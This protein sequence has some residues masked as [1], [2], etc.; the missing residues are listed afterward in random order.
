MIQTD[1]AVWQQLSDAGL[2]K[3]A[4]RPDIAV[5]A[6]WYV[7]ALLA[8]SGWLSA[9]FGFAFIGLT[10]GLLLESPVFS[11]IV[12]LALVVT[13][14]FI[15]RID[16]NEFVDNLGL[17]VSLVGQ[18][19][20]VWGLVT[21]D[22]A[23]N[24]NFVI[25]AISALYAVLILATGSYLHRVVFSIFLVCTVFTWIVTNRLPAMNIMLFLLPIA[26]LWLN[27]FR[28]PARASLVR[29]IAYGL[30]IGLITTIAVAGWSQGFL[31]WL[32][33]IGATG[34]TESVGFASTTIY[35]AVAIASLA[36]VVTQCLR[37]NN[38]LG[39][40]TT[41]LLSL[42]GALLF[43]WVALPAPG[44]ISGAVV[45]LCGFAASNRVLTGLG[46]V[47]LL[48]FMSSYYYQMDTTLLAKS[49]SL[50][51]VGAG[52]LAARLVLKWVPAR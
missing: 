16:G 40:N 33:G 44:V 30:T 47:A 22:D 23:E 11:L 5:P 1:Q 24:L 26:W 35:K 15:S 41:T 43:A 28:W 17:I 42:A 18:A 45:L 2:V 31:G 14:I 7:K 49:I 13:A 12:G 51:T 10:A 6:P 50:A 34:V 32:G 27:E 9:L 3:P 37:N 46:I 19:L 29:A 8:I 52:L 38:R 39:T 21:Y 36:Y 48:S 25:G 4:E 20:F